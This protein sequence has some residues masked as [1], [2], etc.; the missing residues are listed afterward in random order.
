[1]K[2]LDL[3]EDVRNTVDA[4]GKLRRAFKANEEQSFSEE[5]DKLKEKFK[6]AIEKMAKMF[7]RVRPEAPWWY[8]FRRGE[9]V[10]ILKVV[11]DGSGKFWTNE[12]RG[13]LGLFEWMI[14]EHVVVLGPVKALEVG[15]D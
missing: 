9:D 8:W 11:Q 5:L 15:D 1:M 6:E 7:S 2:P 3:N 12:G 10:F 13:G 4:Y 14:A